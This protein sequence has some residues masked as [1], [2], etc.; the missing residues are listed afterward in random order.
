MTS[1]MKKAIFATLLFCLFVTVTLPVKATSEI[2][3]EKTNPSDVYSY[4]LKRFKEKV[5]LTIFYRSPIK[6]TN[7]LKDL[8]Q[9][10]MAELKHV[11]DFKEASY[12]ESSSQRL[13]ATAG[14]ITEV[15]VTNRIDSEKEILK[16]T[17]S[18]QITLLEQLQNNYEYDSAQ[19]M[20]L[21]WDIDYLKLY[22]EKLSD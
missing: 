2:I 10:R 18:E 17:F 5:A 6:K 9:K 14:K 13:S 1:I 20:F 4:N 3:Y 15:I 16:K 11:V 21:K 19:W 8:L 12:L 22:S 7:F